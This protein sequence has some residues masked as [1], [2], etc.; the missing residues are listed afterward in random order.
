MEECQRRCANWVLEDKWR[1]IEKD[2][3]EQNS[4]K[5]DQHRQK[6]RGHP[7]DVEKKY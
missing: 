4:R 5:K 7:L 2:K 6:H 3:G 1:F